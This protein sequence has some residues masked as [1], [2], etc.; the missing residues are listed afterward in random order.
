MVPQCCGSSGII[1]RLKLN[2]LLYDFTFFI[3]S[4]AQCFLWI[5]FS[6][7][8]NAFLPTSCPI[9]HL[10][11]PQ[12]AQHGMNVV[13]IS[14]SRADL[15]VV[16]KEISKKK[17]KPHIIGW[18]HIWEHDSSDQ[19]LRILVPP[20]HVSPD[21]TTGK[22]VKVI[23]ADLTNGSVFGEIEKELKDL[24]IGVLGQMFCFVLSV[25][26][27]KVMRWRHYLTWCS[28]FSTIPSSH[29]SQ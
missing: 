4:K 9:L 27:I 28:S 21:E 22:S 19:L 15:D 26:T 17:N 16:A 8:V 3:W 11:L 6:Y 29:F 2:F 1:Y 23:V 12:L 10:C 25:S 7:N 24:N 5:N 20:Y 18:H 14:R 13:I